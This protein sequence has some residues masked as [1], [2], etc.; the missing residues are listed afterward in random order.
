MNPIVKQLADRIATLEIEKA[1]AIA[2]YVELKK[3]YEE[4]RQAV[5]N[6]NE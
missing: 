6:K 3:E 1:T 2:R 4:Y 5:E